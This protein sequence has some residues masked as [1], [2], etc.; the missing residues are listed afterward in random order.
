METNLVE[1]RKALRAKIP[2]ISASIDVV[3]MLQER[4]AT[5]GAD[6][7]F[8][9]Y[10]ALADQVHAK[11]SIHPRG[12]VSLWLGANVMLEYSY[13]EARTLLETQHAN[14]VTKVEETTEE[15]DILREQAIIT[16]VNMARAL[17]WDVVR[18]RQEKL[19]ALG[20]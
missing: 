14:A 8:S 4:A 6:T 13:E 18:R 1:N 15:L 12:T 17:N 10:F 20:N 11:A 19:A 2:D 16:E 3:R 5:D 9:T 7:P